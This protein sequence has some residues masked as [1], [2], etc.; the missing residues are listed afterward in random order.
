MFFIAPNFSSALIMVEMVSV[1]IYFICVSM[2]LSIQ[3]K[4]RLFSAH[5]LLMLVPVMFWELWRPF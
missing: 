3:C 4:H 2:C 5:L 1:R